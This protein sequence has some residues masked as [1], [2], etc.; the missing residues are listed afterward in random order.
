MDGLSIAIQR[1]A[2]RAELLWIAGTRGSSPEVAR[3]VEYLQDASWRSVG[4]QSVVDIAPYLDQAALKAADRR[5]K[6]GEDAAADGNDLIHQNSWFLCL[7]GSAYKAVVL[8]QIVRYEALLE[9]RKKLMVAL[10]GSPHETSPVDLDMSAKPAKGRAD[11]S[12]DIEKIMAENEPRNEDVRSLHLKLQ[13]DA[14]PGKSQIAIAL[15]F[16]GDNEV[17]ANSLLRGVRRYRNKLKSALED[18]DD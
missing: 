2:K 3:Q 7:I 13:R 18:L 14:G 9:L 12:A 17:R 8:G 5:I 16:T 11:K 1:D 15:E 6:F 10:E 4:V